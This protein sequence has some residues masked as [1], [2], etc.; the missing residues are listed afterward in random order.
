MDFLATESVKWQTNVTDLCVCLFVADKESQT[1]LVGALS[2]LE[3]IILL[4]L[5][6]HQ[7]QTEKVEMLQK[8][9]DYRTHT[10]K[11]KARQGDRKGVQGEKGRG[12]KYTAENWKWVK[13]R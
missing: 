11:D 5:S 7:I 1:I 13:I 4:M 9:A 10:Q 3:V 2:S 12:R 6:H 8:N